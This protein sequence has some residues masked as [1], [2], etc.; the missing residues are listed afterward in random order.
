MAGTIGEYYIQDMG[1]GELWLMQDGNQILMEDED[2]EYDIS[3]IMDRLNLIRLLSVE[4]LRAIL[5]KAL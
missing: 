2:G 1:A 3:D 4:E 5:E